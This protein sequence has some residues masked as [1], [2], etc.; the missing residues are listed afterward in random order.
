MKRLFSFVILVGLYQ[1]ISCFNIKSQNVYHRRSQQ[2]QQLQ[3]Q[4]KQQYNR[5]RIYYMTS[6]SNDEVPRL[7]ADLDGLIKWSEKSG[8][9]VDVKVKI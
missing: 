5:R 8:A 2:Q 1:I 9:K 3:L 4:Q 7:H 6:K